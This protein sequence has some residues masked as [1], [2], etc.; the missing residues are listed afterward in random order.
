MS[1]WFESSSGVA[2]ADDELRKLDG[3]TRDKAVQA[4][5]FAELENRVAARLRIMTDVIEA[6]RTGGAQAAIAAVNTDRGKNVMDDIREQVARMTRE[7]QRI[8]EIRTADMAAAS[9]AAVISTVV[10]SSSG[11]GLT[12]A[13]FVLFLRSTRSR[14]RQQW[15]QAAWPIWARR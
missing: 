10:T 1:K 3:L 4:E 9:R 7:E 11:I 5:S 14:E 15:L 13:I 8:R 12:I 2:R 6:R